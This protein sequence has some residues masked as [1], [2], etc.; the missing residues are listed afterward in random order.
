[1]SQN[2]IHQ[3][4]KVKEISTED[5]ATVGEETEGNS[6]TILPRTNRQ[7]LVIVKNEK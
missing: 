3:Q 2:H 7:V 4:L 5:I 1:M 6:K